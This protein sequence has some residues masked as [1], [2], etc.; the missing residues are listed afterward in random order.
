MWH[1]AFFFQA[2]ANHFH[3]LCRAVQNGAAG[4]R[5][6]GGMRLGVP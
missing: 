4:K 5:Q 2:G 6:P 3:A 1:R